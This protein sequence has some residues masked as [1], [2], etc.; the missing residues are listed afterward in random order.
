[1][2]RKRSVRAL[3]AGFALLGTVW[4]LAA[5]FG[6][7]LLIVRAEP[8]RADA[9]IVLS[10]S[11]LYAERTRYAASI[12][13]QGRARAIVLTDDGLAGPWS[14]ERQRNPRSI[15][16]GRDILLGSGVPP[17]DV[18][19]LPG[20]VRSTYDEAL[21]AHAYARAQRL[22]SLL[23]VTSP[24]HTRRALW[25]FNRVLAADG[26]AVGVDPVPLGDQSPAPGVWWL[27]RSGWQ[28]VA[29]E[30]PKFLYYV[31]VYR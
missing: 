7:R 6:A 10:G 8:S 13:H 22:R 3:L 1:V 27:S 23:I 2:L 26:V 19:I 16:R 20:R 28:N 29:S 11:A 14:R 9:I 31:L 18:V 21:A 12:Y 15:E 5:P 4:V 25:V 30:Y 24:Y 17:D